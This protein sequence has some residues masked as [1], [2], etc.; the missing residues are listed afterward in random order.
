[1]RFLSLLRMISACLLL[2]GMAYAQ[3]VGASGD[4]TG[5]VTD[6]TGAVITKGTVTATDA[7]KGLK[8]SADTDSDGRYTIAG[9]QPAVYN[10]SVSKSG[11]QT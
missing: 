1:M 6:P 9:L 10:I 7:A 8:R 11:F 2:S 5:I 3:G 4:I